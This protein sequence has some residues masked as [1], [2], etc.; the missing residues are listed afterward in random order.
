MVPKYNAGDVTISELVLFDFDLL[1]SGTDLRRWATEQAGL[2]DV[3]QE[4]EACAARSRSLFCMWRTGRDYGEAALSCDTLRST[5]L[6]AL[7]GREGGLLLCYMPV[8]PEHMGSWFSSLWIRDH[9]GFTVRGG[10]R[11]KK[12]RDRFSAAFESQRV[13]V[14]VE[15]ASTGPEGTTTDVRPILV[16]Q[17]PARRCSF[18]P[19]YQWDLVAFIAEQEEKASPSYG[20]RCE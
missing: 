9:G 3:L 16:E 1:G 20:S 7:A 18:V 13:F 11:F 15:V 5:I 4:I 8:I 14:N 6:S 2:A 19:P 10:L 17:I 12:E